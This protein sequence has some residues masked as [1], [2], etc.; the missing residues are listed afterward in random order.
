MVFSA[1][2]LLGKTVLVT[3]ASSGIGAVS[4]TVLVCNLNDNLN[5]NYSPVLGSGDPLCQGEYMRPA[6]G[7]SS[8]PLLYEGRVECDSHG[9][10]T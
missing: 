9:S 6:F 3:G 7:M 1:S 8:F 2:R 4:V 10:S 5:D